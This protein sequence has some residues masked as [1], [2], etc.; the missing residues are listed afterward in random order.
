MLMVD[1]T[2]FNARGVDFYRGLVYQAMFSNG[3]SQYLAGLREGVVVAILN[4]G[5]SFYGVFHV[6]LH[7]A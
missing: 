3:F 4:Q 7:S 5:H 6:A 2:L 1:Q